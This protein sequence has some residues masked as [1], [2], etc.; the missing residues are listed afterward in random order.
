MKYYAKKHIK[1]FGYIYIYIYSQQ[2]SNNLNQNYSTIMQKKFLL[3]TICLFLANVAS[4]QW[5]GGYSPN[6][7]YDPC[8]QAAIAVANSYNN[9]VQPG[10]NVVMQ[11]Q[12]TMINNGWYCPNNITYE[13]VKESC[14]NCD[15]G[16][17]Y[18]KQY[19]GGGE[20]RTVKRCCGICHGKGYVYKRVIVVN[21]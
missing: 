19:M 2:I 6:V 7:M 3:A 16:Y 17:I 5:Y 8:V 18:S 20:T 21:D 14:D 1:I 12:Q 10:W 13:T 4:A 9:T 11:Q 15:D